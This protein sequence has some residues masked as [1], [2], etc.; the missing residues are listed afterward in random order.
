[1]SMKSSQ[2]MFFCHGFS[3]SLR[4]GSL[5]SRNNM[6]LEGFFSFFFFFEAGSCSVAQAGV[7]WLYLSSLQALPPSFKLSLCLS[8]LSIWD[9][10]ITSMHHHAW[11]IFVIVVD[12]GFYHVGQ[13]ALAFL[14]SSDPPALVSQ[15]AGIA[16]VSH[17]TQP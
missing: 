14:A 3:L 16:G 17:C 15:S 13:A 12:I 9:S 11:L 7:Q 10:G 6:C 5:T 2:F 1:M 8:L 4:S